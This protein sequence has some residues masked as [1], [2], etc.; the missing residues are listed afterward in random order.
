MFEQLAF[1]NNY[2]NYV[3][4]KNGCILIGNKNQ[5]KREEM[6]VINST[7]SS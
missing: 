5:T 6:K 2:N 3:S 4:L 7:E 1:P